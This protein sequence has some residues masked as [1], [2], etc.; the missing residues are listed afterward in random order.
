MLNMNVLLDTDTQF[1]H[2]SNSH[3]TCRISPIPLNELTLCEA[4]SCV[5]AVT[6]NWRFSVNLIITNTK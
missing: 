2:C 4:V 5:R 3:L 6:G 1:S